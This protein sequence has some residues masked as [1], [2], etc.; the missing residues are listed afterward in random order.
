MGIDP[1]T[2]KPRLDL[3]QLYSILNSSLCTNNND[4]DSSS[5]INFSNLLGMVNPNMHNLATPLPSH[6][7]NQEYR[8]DNSIQEDQIVDGSTNAEFLNETQYN[9]QPNFRGQ[10]SLESATR[11]SM[12]QNSGYYEIINQPMINKSSCENQSNLGF[13]SLISTPSSNTTPLRSS[14]T[15][16]YVNGSTE[17]ERD[18]YCGNMLMFDISNGFS[19]NGFL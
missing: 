10:N 5:Q 19:V 1:V 8:F 6:L 17:D 2:H 4:N 18:S 7:I 16:S 3:L 14:S 12:M 9:L 13:S 11:K 15:L